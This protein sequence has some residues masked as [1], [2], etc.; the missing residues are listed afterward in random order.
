MP[1]NSQVAGRKAD[2]IRINLE[3]DVQSGVTTGLERFRFLNEALPDLNLAEVVLSQEL[4]G[5]TVRA[6]ILIS[7]MTGGTAEAGEINRRLAEAARLGFTRAI[8]PRHGS[9]DVRLPAGMRVVRV[10]DVLGA[11]A[12]G[13]RME[14]IAESLRARA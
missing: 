9:E 8:I 11:I 1:D 10:D 5:R 4:F 2:H 7:S 6:P 3:A 13:H 12:A 14:T